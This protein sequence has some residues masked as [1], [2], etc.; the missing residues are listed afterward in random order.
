[1][2][3]ARSPVQTRS[4]VAAVQ[5]PLW[6]PPVGAGSGSGLQDRWGPSVEAVEIAPVGA[7][8]RGTSFSQ[9]VGVAGGE[10]FSWDEPE[11]M[12]EL[13]GRTLSSSAV[14]FN[15][16]NAVMRVSELKQVH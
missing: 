1:M 4:R 9:A 13:G 5:E 6:E 8:E 16:K 10:F 15:R 7:P 3:P 11:E 2:Q 14:K 12:E